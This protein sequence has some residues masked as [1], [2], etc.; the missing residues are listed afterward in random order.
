MLKYFLF[1]DVH[2]TSDTMV[3]LG[4]ENWTAAVKSCP[5]FS[6]LHLL[7][8]VLESCIKWEKS[9]ENA[10][11]VLYSLSIVDFVILEI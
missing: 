6:R 11:C 7:L 4:I 10:V 1:I 3:C 2:N 9:A 8:S 5:T